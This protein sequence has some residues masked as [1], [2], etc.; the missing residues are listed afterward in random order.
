MGIESEMESDKVNSI[1]F[2]LIAYLSIP[3]IEVRPSIDEVQSVLVHAGKII[4][5]VSKGVA[6]WRKS[7]KPKSANQNTR[8]N[9][10]I[11]NSESAREMR[12]YSA[13]KE[14]KP[15]ITE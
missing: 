1:V 8:T 14:E 6:T 7:V 15:V 11:P 9:N 2:V 4:L 13:K 3:D 12:L 10:F 5:S